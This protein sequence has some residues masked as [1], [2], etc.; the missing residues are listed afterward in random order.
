MSNYFKFFLGF[1]FFLILLMKWSLSSKIQ[2]TKFQLSFKIILLFYLSLHIL[3]IYLYQIQIFQL[4]LPN[5][6]FV[7]R[8]LGLNQIVY[9]KCE[10]PAHYYLNQDIEW[11]QVV[12][13]FILFILYWFIA[14]DFTYTHRNFNDKHKTSTKPPPKIEITEALYQVNFKANKDLILA[15]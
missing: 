15:N 8:I 5:T 12:Y 14:I 10:Q 7:A 1:L 2:N 9:T 3:A 11:M 13:P 4:A 6:E